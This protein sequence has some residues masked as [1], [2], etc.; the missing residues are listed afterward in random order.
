MILMVMAALTA[1]LRPVEDGVVDGG[2][3]AVPVV[4]AVREL[5]GDTVVSVIGDTAVGDKDV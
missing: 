1:A 5:K 3:A 4:A 2:G